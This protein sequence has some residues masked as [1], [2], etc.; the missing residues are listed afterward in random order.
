[1]N[2]FLWIRGGVLSGL[3]NPARPPI[4]LGTPIDHRCFFSPRQYIHLL[5]PPPPPHETI[6]LPQSP[7]WIEIP[8]LV[9]T[10]PEDLAAPEAETAP[11]ETALVDAASETGRVLEAASESEAALEVG[12]AAETEP[13]AG[14]IETAL[15]ALRTECAAP[16]DMS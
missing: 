3:P 2:T 4:W 11:V 15:E 5:H 13:A 9:S 16:A 7:L 1:M 10:N 14:E 6:W 12:T 8:A